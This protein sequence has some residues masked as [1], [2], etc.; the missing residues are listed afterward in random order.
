[1]RIT[2]PTAALYHTMTGPIGKLSVLNNGIDL[3]TDENAKL[4]F[5]NIKLI[6][7]LVCGCG[8]SG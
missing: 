5:G 7:S 4:S 6:E 8:V 1:M 2:N 3:S